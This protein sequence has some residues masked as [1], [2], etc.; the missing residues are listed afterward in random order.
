MR[1]DKRDATSLRPLS[2][3]QSVLSRIDG[4]A[5][6]AF[7]DVEVLAGVTGPAEVRLKDE[8]ADKAVLEVNVRPL[9]G[10]AGP[11]NK[12]QEH[13]LHA[14]FAPLIQLNTLPRSLIQVTL[15]T[16]SLPTLAFSKTLSTS[17]EATNGAPRRFESSA[18]ERAA[19]VN[20]MTC[21]LM[22]AAVPMRG[23][24]IAVS[25][26]IL[27]GGQQLVLDP[28]AQEEG[29]AASLHTLV[30]SF[31]EG[32]GGHEGDLVGIESSGDFTED[33]VRALPPL[34]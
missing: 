33:E 18:S 23:L 4:S 1:R 30:F 8:L 14:N 20:A 16:V 29:A 3:T 10:V 15:Q 28:T 21:A 22:D 34:S 17:L 32:V 6:F 13:A 19:L 24:L 5:K 25:A 11:A 27:R 31:G 12:A 2:L 7:G 26:A 9:R